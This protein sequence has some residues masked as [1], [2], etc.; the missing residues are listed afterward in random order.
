MLKLGKTRLAGS[1][2]GLMI[3][4]ASLTGCGGGN[5][6]N[7][8]VAGVKYNATF[9][10]GYFLLSVAFK[11]LQLDG[12]GR[13]ALDPKKLPNSYAE[14]GP[15]FQSNGT[16]LVVGLAAKDVLNASGT[17]I[18]DPHTLP[19]GRPLPG[20]TAGV[21]PGMALN[22]GDKLGNLSVYFGN[23]AF[24]VF[25]PVKLGCKDV[26]ATFRFYADNARVGNISLVCEDASGK[27]GGFLALVNKT[28]PAV[29]SVLSRY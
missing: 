17:S 22:L 25:V 7:P 29:Q 1:I 28:I 3:M 6:K 12:G 9:V 23:G 10:D 5:N 21:L 19:G 24:G 20:V 2:A 13:F 8:D 15:D 4:T 11:N 16:L 14:L 26:I 18:F 27:N